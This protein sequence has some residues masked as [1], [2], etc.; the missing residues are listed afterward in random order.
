MI[1]FLSILLRADSDIVQIYKILQII[2][3]DIEPK[4]LIRKPSLDTSILS[5]DPFTV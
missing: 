2:N 3:F 5:G 1:G 4:T